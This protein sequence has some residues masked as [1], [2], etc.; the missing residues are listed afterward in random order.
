MVRAGHSRG[1][2]MFEL[3]P[4]NQ[5]RLARTGGLPQP[6]QQHQ[7]MGARDCPLLQSAFRGLR[8]LLWPSCPEQDR[9]LRKSR[10]F[11]IYVIDRKRIEIT[12][13]TLTLR[14]GFGN[15]LLWARSQPN[16]SREHADYSQGGGFP[17]P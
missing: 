16:H 11:V 12:I 6:R 14:S 1:A 3:A 17:R 5:L 10:I 7:T 8:L 9:R 15:W 4:L 13:G 2:Q